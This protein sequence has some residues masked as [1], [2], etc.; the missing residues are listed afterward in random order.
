MGARAER[1][2]IFARSLTRQGRVTRRRG[3]GWGSGERRQCPQSASRVTT[4]IHTHAR[5]GP[6]DWLAGW[7]AGCVSFLC[8]PVFQSTKA[9]SSS[10]VAA[11]HARAPRAHMHHVRG[12]RGRARA[13][14]S[15]HPYV[16][17]ERAKVIQSGAFGDVSVI[18]AARYIVQE[19]AARYSPEERG[20]S[21]SST[22][23]A[24]VRGRY[25][26]GEGMRHGERKRRE[27][28]R[29]SEFER[30]REAALGQSPCPVVPSSMRRSSRDV[31][32]V[33]WLTWKRACWASKIELAI[34]PRQSNK[35]PS[36]RHRAI[37]HR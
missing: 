27:I 10:R 5:D 2:R 12:A 13:H 23:N 4:T 6:N 8:V 28:D 1:G 21:S 7:L 15:H 14:V 22:E 32:S 9:S 36:G 20:I 37:R 16:P 19:F 24:R 30:E 11:Y 34:V 31:T 26:N 17:T 35:Y 3:P 29:E 33:S 25:I 18:I